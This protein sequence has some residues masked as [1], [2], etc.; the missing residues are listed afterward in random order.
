MAA[1]SRAAFFSAA[2][3]LCPAALEHFRV[4]RQRGKSRKQPLHAAPCPPPLALYCFPPCRGGRVRGSVWERM[5]GDIHSI[6]P[7]GLRWRGVIVAKVGAVPLRGCSQARE[8]N[9]SLDIGAGFAVEPGC[10]QGRLTEKVSGANAVAS[11]WEGWHVIEACA[12]PPTTLQTG[13][14]KGQEC[15]AV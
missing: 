10:A 9:K 14:S 5:K 2:Q 6:S 8:W 15:S 13:G 1:V 7:P 11:G 12:C 3:P 4:K